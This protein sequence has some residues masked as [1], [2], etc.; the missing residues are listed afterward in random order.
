MALITLHLNRAIHLRKQHSE[1]KTDNNF[2]EKKDKE[3][4]IVLAGVLK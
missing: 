3:T 2:N 4:K 1:I